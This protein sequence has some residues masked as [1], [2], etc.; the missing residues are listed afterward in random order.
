M[1]TYYIDFR[2]IVFIILLVQ[3][4]KESNDKTFLYVISEN[5]FIELMKS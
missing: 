2:N 1:F 5:N 4:E 3:T